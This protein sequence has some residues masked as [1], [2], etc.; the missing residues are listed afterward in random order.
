[1]E[2]EIYFT[3]KD[4]DF[5]QLSVSQPISVQGGAY[6]TKIKINNAPLYIQPTKCYTRQGLSE[7]NKKAYMDLMFTNEDEEVIEWFE[8]LEQHLTELIYEKRELWFQN[9]MEKEDIEHFFNPI[10]RAFKGGKYHLVRINIPKNKT[11]SSQYFCNVYDENENIIPIQELNDTHSIIPCLEVQGIKFSARN[12]QVDL[13]GKQIM[14]LNN[15]PIFNSCVI[16]REVTHNINTVLTET[17]KNIVSKSMDTINNVKKEKQETN[18]N[19]LG[20]T[21]IEDKTTDT[22]Q[23][24]DPTTI[25]G[26]HRNIIDT[27]VD[28]SSDDDDTSVNNTHENNTHEN[29]THENNTHEND[30]HENNTHEND[31]Y[32]NDT[33]ENNTKNEIYIPTPPIPTY[34]EKNSD[35]KINK[36]TNDLE[37]IT[38]DLII[39]DKQNITLRRPN[40]VYYEIY[41]I[42]KYKARQQKKAAITHYLEAKKIKNTYLLND[43]DNSEDDEDDEDDEE[44]VDDDDDDDDEQ[45]HDNIKQNNQNE[46]NRIKTQINKMVEE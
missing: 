37:D 26:L 10:C 18:G 14:L 24:N 36:K 22:S 6:F 20:T 35:N 39:N 12:F 2:Q 34:L 27:L 28:S 46:A 44:D 31:T 45:H 4:F 40:E 21:G 7:T 41:K 19:S 5:S 17:E 1:M 11:I 42:A 33:H 3:N 9:E 32:E 29:D 16:K 23:E 25:K 43:L 13:I 8:H 38:N 15:K 30:T